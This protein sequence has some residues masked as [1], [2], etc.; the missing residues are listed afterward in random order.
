MLLMVSLGRQGL[1]QVN[2][3]WF[4]H[5]ENLLAWLTLVGL[6]I[7]NFLIKF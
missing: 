1:S 6:A 5:N 4:E 3:H 2:S 7:L